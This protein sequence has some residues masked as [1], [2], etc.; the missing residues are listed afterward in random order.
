MKFLDQVKIF[1][2]AG[3]GG[4]GSPSFRREKFIEFGGPDG[5]DGG[6]GGSVIL[7]SERNLNTLIDFR[8]QQH[9]K[10]KRGSDGKGKNQTGRGGE[11]LY[12]KVPVGTQVFEEDNKTLIFDFK[13]ETE[14]FV[15][16]VGGKGGF[17]N[18]RFK[19]STNRAPKKFTKGTKGEDF[20]IWLQLKTIADIGI[21]GLPNAGKSSLLAA[22]TSAT[23]KIAN[24]KFTTLNPNLGVTVYDD[25]EITLADIPG[26]IEGAHE[27]I[28]LGIKFLKHIERCK[29]LLHMIDI[30]EEDLKKSYSQ[31]RKELKNYSKDLLKKDEI[32]VLNKTDLLKDK[33]VKKIKD[34]FLKKYKV[35]L[36]TLSTLDKKSI[37]KIKSKII[38]YVS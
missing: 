20:W 7:K 8:Y 37:S 9:F 23:P 33:E 29:S 18:T 30:T 4:S 27:G 2:K 15:V 26:L 36:A 5:G 11:N 12:L 3:D 1:I 22:I 13:E 17:G 34:D 35:N 24:Y 10:A 28:G 31:V 16:A 25:K 21:I 6:K 32:V 19:S 14:E 38:K